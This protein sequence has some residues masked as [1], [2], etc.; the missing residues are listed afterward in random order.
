V[1]A[2][3]IHQQLDAGAIEFVGARARECLTG[4]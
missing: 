3:P 2:L 4:T 1:L